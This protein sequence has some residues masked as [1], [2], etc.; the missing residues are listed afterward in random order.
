MIALATQNM[1]GAKVSFK[2]CSLTKLFCND[3]SVDTTLCINTL[4]HLPPD[5][6]SLALHE[7]CRVSQKHVIIEIKNTLSPYHG[8]KKMKMLKKHGLKIFG[9]SYFTVKHLFNAYE[10]R[11]VGTRSWLQLGTLLS[12]ILCILAEKKSIETF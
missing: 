8:L 6:F 7:F 12:P 5:D 2:T 11:I 3:A 10:Y 1:S 4:H 9:S